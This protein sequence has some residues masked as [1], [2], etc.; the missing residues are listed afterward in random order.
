MNK[1]KLS[2]LLAITAIL[3]LSALQSCK[4]DIE[5]TGDFKETAV[6]YGLLDKSDSIHLIKITRAFIGPGN[7]LQIAQIPDSNYFNSVNATISERVSGTV[8][9]TWQLFDTIVQN[10][11]TSGVFYA[12]EQKVYAFY[13]RG[14]DNSSNPSYQSLNDNATYE[15]TI[16]INEGTADEFTVTSQTEIVSGISTST[17]N[18]NYQFKFASNAQVTGE[19]ATTSLFAQTGNSA[20]INTAITIHYSDFVGSDTIPQ[21]IRWRLGEH[22]VGGT[23]ESFVMNGRTFYDLVAADCASGD[24]NVFKR[25]LDGLTVTVVAGSEELYNYILIN[26]PSTSLAQNK[27][28]YTNLQATGDHPVIGIFASRYTHTVY[29]PMVSPLSQ[30]IR[31]IDRNSTMELCIGPVTGSHLFCSQQ[32][33]DIA[34][35]QSFACN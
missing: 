24:P 2:L 3:S 12:P 8:T 34:T 15:L 26:Q 14:K 16:V 18:L 10:K 7:S 17:D 5:I 1:M 28:T 31:C 32:T 22:E 35:N 9:R 30:N 4:E 25:N 13:T 20:V 27:P 23:S 33:L 19:Y 29:H 6:V 11:E 21:T